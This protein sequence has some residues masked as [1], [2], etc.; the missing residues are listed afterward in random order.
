MISIRFATVP[1]IRHPTWLDE[2]RLAAAINAFT[3]AR[4]REESW[5]R[6]CMPPQPIDND[7]LDRAVPTDRPVRVTD[8]EH[9][10]YV[11][12]LEDAANA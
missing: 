6:Q 7:E 9:P 3:R 4:M 12:G 11:A 2:P 5:Y 1:P 10:E 8:P